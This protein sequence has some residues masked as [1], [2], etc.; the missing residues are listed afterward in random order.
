M[1]VLGAFLTIDHVPYAWHHQLVVRVQSTAVCSVWLVVCGAS[2]Y[3]HGAHT[4]LA[5]TYLST[6]CFFD[7]PIFGHHTVS[8]PQTTTTAKSFDLLYDALLERLQGPQRRMPRNDDDDDGNNGHYHDDDDD[9]IVQQQQMILARTI[10]YSCIAGT[11]PMQILLLYDR[12]WQVQ[13]WPIPIILGCTMGWIIGTV[14]GTILAVT[15]TKTA[16]TER[17]LFNTRSR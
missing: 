15:T 1:A 7:P 2:P 5:A 17:A 13:R 9:S 10:W 16:H 6:L 8:H 4:L 11:I 14:L 3:Q 12:G